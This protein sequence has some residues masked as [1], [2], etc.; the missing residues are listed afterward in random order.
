MLDFVEIEDFRLL[1]VCSVSD[2][3]KNDDDF[4]KSSCFELISRFFCKILLPN[5]LAVLVESKLIKKL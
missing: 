1:P 2:V 3:D 4:G 5:E